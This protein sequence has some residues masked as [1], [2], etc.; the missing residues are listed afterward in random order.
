MGVSPGMGGHSTLQSLQRDPSVKDKAV[1]P[2][3]SRRV[4]GLLKPYRGRIAVF[5]ALV[6]VEAVIGV[7]DPLIYREI[8]NGGILGG[9][10]ALVVRLALTRRSWSG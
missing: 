6:T 5:L 9:D 7:L 8:I 4:V 1:A 2:G 3:T 10:A